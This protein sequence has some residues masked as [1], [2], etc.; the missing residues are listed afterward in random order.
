[1]SVP[2]PAGHRRGLLPTLGLLLVPSSLAG[3]AGSVVCRALGR[4]IGTDMVLP[5][6]CSSSPRRAR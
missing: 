5:V 2:S 3:V 4:R 1:M 6:G